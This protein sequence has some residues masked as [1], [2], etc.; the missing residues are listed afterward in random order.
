MNSYKNLAIAATFAALMLLIL[1]SPAMTQ[2]MMTLGNTPP[3]PPLGR[4]FL[5]ELTAY[6]TI[7]HL[8]YTNKKNNRYFLRVAAQRPRGYPAYMMLV[9][10]D[11]PVKS[12]EV[13]VNAFTRAGKNI[14]FAVRIGYKKSPGSPFREYLVSSTGLNNMYKSDSNDFVVAYDWISFDLELDFPASASREEQRQFL[15]TVPDYTQLHFFDYYTAP[16]SQTRSPDADRLFLDSVDRV[17]P[18]V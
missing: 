10:Q 13:V 2:G 18:A 11:A 5:P 17:A 6:N 4:R 3:P 9:R 16:E 8:I 12:V 7:H 15:L 1:M 14:G